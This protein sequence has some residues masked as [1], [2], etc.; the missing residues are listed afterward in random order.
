MSE[1]TTQQAAEELAAAREL[2]ESLTEAGWTL[3]TMSAFLLYSTRFFTAQEQW[4]AI[5]DYIN[6]RLPDYPTGE[7]RSPE[8]E[9]GLVFSLFH[10]MMQQLNDGSS[11]GEEF[12]LQ[13]RGL[14]ELGAQLLASEDGLEELNR[15]MLVFDQQHIINNLLTGNHD[16]L[17]SLL[18]RQQNLLGV[19]H[20]FEDQPL[21]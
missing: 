18:I 12:L 13:L 21:I 2:I 19:A 20:L 7:G 3:H 16:I 1:E 14:R 11:S 10:M 15:V 6:E 17:R 8:L 9:Q 4:A 5:D